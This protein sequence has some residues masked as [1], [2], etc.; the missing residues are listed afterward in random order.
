MSTPIP[1]VHA[2]TPAPSIDALLEPV[3]GTRRPWWRRRAALAGAA[4]VLVALLVAAFVS[5]LVGAPSGS[6]RTAAVTERAV[7]AELT[8]VATIEPVAQAEVGFPTSGTVASV[9]VRVGDRVA[10]GDALAR[11]DTREL[12]QQLHSAE[13]TLAQAELTLHN[14]LNGQKAT[15]PGGAAVGGV[16][17]NVSATTARADTRVVFTSASTDPELAAAQQAVLQAQQQ[18]DAALAAASTAYD[19]A[20][21]VCTAVDPDT[22]ACQS[23]L[24]AALDAQ[25]EVQ[26]AQHVLVDVSIAY[27]DLLAERAARDGGDDPEVVP[28][29]DPTPDPG[30]PGIAPEGGGAPAGGFSGGA[31]T[32]APS[33]A[34]LIA[35]Q[36]SVDAAAAGVATARQAIE[37]AT[38]TTPIAGTVVAIGFRAGASV[39]DPT[40]QHVVVQGDGGM[41]ATTVVAVD[42]VAA[43]EIGQRARVLPDGGDEVLG[44]TV[45]AISVTPIASGSSGSANYRVTVALDDPA[46][47]LP[48][49]GTG[50]V[51][52]V[53]DQSDRGVAVPTSAISSVAGRYLVTV[54]EGDDIRQVTVEVGVIG[55]AWT[56]ITNGLEVGDE[57]VLADLDEPLPSSATESGSGGG[58]TFPG[59]APPGFG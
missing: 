46:A 33:S 45:A 28:P 9:S 16:A 36:Q 57:V 32:S 29:N 49:G 14:G 38:I 51:A 56:S 43:I 34:D 1:A 7:D 54:V 52:V 17:T 13:S 26:T 25:T 48:N 37:Q 42:D 12:E 5:G 3:G 31:T 53:T 39:D 4:L 2:V 50:T 30:D 55:R 15:G 21:A 35:Y 47:A 8:S 27:D 59:G 24:Q 58:F 18:V 40:T 11:L 20:V 41:E 10:A 23:A 44:G 6:Y 22:A 19:N